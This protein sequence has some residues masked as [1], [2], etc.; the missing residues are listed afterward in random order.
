MAAQ[1]DERGS[2]RYGK[3]RVVLEY[4]RRLAQRG[5]HQDAESGTVS[6]PWR[7]GDAMLIVR[8]LAGNRRLGLIRQSCLLAPRG[9]WGSSRKVTHFFPAT[10]SSLLIRMEWVAATV[11]LAPVLPTTVAVC[12]FPS[13]E[14]AVSASGEIINRGVPIREP[15]PRLPI[16]LTTDGPAQNASSYVTA[17]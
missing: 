4:Y 17:Q 7:L 15:L 13:V 10:R 9:R 16:L 6:P 14:K 2:V 1:W 5:S 8:W 11:R 12:G 3:G